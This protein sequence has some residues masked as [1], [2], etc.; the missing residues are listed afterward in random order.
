MLYQSVS[1][2]LILVIT[3]AT[4]ERMSYNQF[5]LKLILVIFRKHGFEKKLG[6]SFK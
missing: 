6:K 2:K 1:L 3:T 4:K 5:I